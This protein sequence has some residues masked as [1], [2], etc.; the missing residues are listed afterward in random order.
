MLGRIPE[1]EIATLFLGHDILVL[2]YSASGGYSGAM[3]AAAPFGIGVVAY[4]LPQL[5]ETAAELG[6]KVR[7]IPHD[8][9]EAVRAGISS[10]LDTPETSRGPVLPLSTLLERSQDAVG[11]LLAYF[12]ASSDCSHRSDPGERD[13]LPGRKD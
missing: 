8:R 5:R 3:N 12:S 4:D 9:E 1:E 2:P 13:G 11:R 10:A 6:L 7:F